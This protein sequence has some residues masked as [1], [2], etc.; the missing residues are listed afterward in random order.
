M[1]FVFGGIFSKKNQPV[2]SYRC[3]IKIFMGGGQ[4]WWV[5]GRSGVVGDRG[6]IRGSF[7]KHLKTE[8]G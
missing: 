5:G 1:S 4:G 2:V 8:G 7:Q 6:V 3:M